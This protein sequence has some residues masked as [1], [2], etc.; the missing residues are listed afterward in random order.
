M[1]EL[2]KQI[3]HLEEMI[4]SK[5]DGSG[6][7]ADT[8][9]LEKELKSLKLAWE[10]LEHEHNLLPCPACKAVGLAVHHKHEKKQIS[11]K[12]G[13]SGPF[14]LTFHLAIEGWNEMQHKPGR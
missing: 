13:V 2:S 12:C 3:A 7:R 6:G 5:Q 8:S 4:Q 11:C 9:A 14:R 1:D 10:Q